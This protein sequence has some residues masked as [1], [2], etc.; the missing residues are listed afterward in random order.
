[1][2]KQDGRGQVSRRGRD[3]FRG[4]EVQSGLKCVCHT[5]VWGAAGVFGWVRGGQLLRLTE[6]DG[7]DQ[8]VSGRRSSAS[9]RAAGA[10]LAE[11]ARG[12]KLKNLFIPHG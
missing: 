2:K 8:S 9:C 6:D 11:G 1:M 12:V 4:D 7:G 10:I 5:P 3:K